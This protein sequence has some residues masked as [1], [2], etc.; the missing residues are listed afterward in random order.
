MKSHW[1]SPPSKEFPNSGRVKGSLNGPVSNSS[2]AKCQPDC[3][4]WEATVASLNVTFFDLT[5]HL[6][7]PNVI[8]MAK[9][10]GVDSIWANES[11]NPRPV[12]IDLRDKTGQDVAG[13]FSTEVGIGQYGITVLDHANGMAT[14]AAGGKR[15]DAHFVRSVTRGGEQVYAEKIAT[16]DVGLDQ[17]QINELNWT[18]SK[19][20][21]AKLN[22]GWDSAGKTGTWQHGNSTTENSNAWMVGYTRAL[23]AAVWLGTT[24][25]KPLITTGGSTQV[26]GASYPGP[27]W[28]QFMVRTLAAMK[29]DPNKY[30]FEAP[31]WPDEAP[32]ESP[33]PAPT[34]PSPSPSHPKPSCPPAGCPSPSGSP[35]GSK[36]P[37]PSVSPSNPKTPPPKLPLGAGGTHV[38]LQ[39]LG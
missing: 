37:K 1:D 7:V 29:L 27:I 8:D 23:A 5:E 19:V 14:F 36:S 15:V 9:H 3:M 4:L 38:P 33:S 13:K 20:E 31:K 17:E 32:S 18:L 34:T 2:T 26:F 28:R 16:N 11:G 24:D 10:A 25:G 30:R 21:A 12:R 39:L 35:S 22:N 6:G